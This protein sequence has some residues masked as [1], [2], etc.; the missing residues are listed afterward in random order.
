MNLRSLN[1]CQTRDDSK[2]GLSLLQHV[3]LFQSGEG[4]VQSEFEAADDRRGL[5]KAKKEEGL[6][7]RRP[8]IKTVQHKAKPNLGPCTN[9]PRKNR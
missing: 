5:E 9:L 3:L 7:T 8:V 4:C 1:G 2:M 6:E